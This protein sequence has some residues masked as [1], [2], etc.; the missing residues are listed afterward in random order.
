MH[1]FEID[2]VL[3]ARGDSF[4]LGPLSL[5]LARGEI[6]GVMGPNGAGK[7]TL[8]RLL[9]GFMRPDA[10]TISVL[11]MTPHL[12][13]IR[14]RRHAGFVSDSVRFY[15]WMSVERYLRFVAGFYPSFDWEWACRLREDLGL[16]GSA[17]IG[18]LSRGNRA[19]LALVSAVAHQP[20]LLILD[21][22]TSGLDPLVR[23]EVLGILKKMAE[24]G[25]GIV[26]ASHVSSDL[27]QVAG[28]ILMLEGGRAIEYAPA[29]TLLDRYGRRRLEEVFI[30]AIERISRSGAAH[31][32]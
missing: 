18:E 29:R 14:I 30:H 11:G 5:K 25:V 21:E 3:K 10:G 32:A 8:L 1:L 26:L 19:K 4:I 7:T 20:A 15:E 17:R 16:G 12:D 24:R 2:Q 27:D 9:W 22:P 28:S 13:Q 6:L 31:R 23:A